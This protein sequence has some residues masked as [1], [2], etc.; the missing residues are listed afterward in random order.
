MRQHYYSNSSTSCYLNREHTLLLSTASCFALIQAH[1]LSFEAEK[2]Q[3]PSEVSSVLQAA[4]CFLCFRKKGRSIFRKK[5]D[6]PFVQ[7]FLLTATTQQILSISRIRS[8]KITCETGCSWGSRAQRDAT[9]VPSPNPEYNLMWMCNEHEEV[10]G[11]M[12]GLSFH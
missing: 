1:W 9:N 11:R 8:T 7:H 2:P 5:T 12:R 3:N 4:L 10:G 6:I